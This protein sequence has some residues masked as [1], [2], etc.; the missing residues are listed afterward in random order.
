[1]VLLETADNALD[2]AAILASRT[3]K[4]LPAQA[5]RVYQALLIPA[6][7]NA[8]ERS[9]VNPS[10]VTF[11][12]PA[13]IIAK[14]LGISRMT[15]WRAVQVLQA[16]GLI[17]NR[18]H[19]ASLRCRGGQVRN[20][21]S[22][23]QVRLTPNHGSKAKLSYEEMRHAWRP[24][25]ND[26]IRQ[27]R[28][29]HAAIKAA[30]GRNVTY[31]S[32]SQDIDLDLLLKH[33][34]DSKKHLTP[35]DNSVCNKPKNA[36][37]EVLLDVRYAAPGKAT[38]QMVDTAASALSQALADYASVNFYRLLVW[39]CLRASQR[40]LDVFPMV[41]QIAIRARVDVQENF[42]RKGGAVFVSRLK[43]TEFYEFVMNAPPTRVGTLPN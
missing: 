41:Y 27:G 13:E 3:P 35:V 34:V 19:K 26:E 24:N 18:A 25:F 4:P 29:S 17:D 14:S 42:S 12:C 40:G 1:M 38:V 16:E 11:H 9:Y 39:R 7:E 2:A 33:S 20:T 15:L 5:K 28:G 36:V 30:R 10:R 23:W 22:V 43:Q 8:R 31:K 21:G 32:N 37:L 6:L